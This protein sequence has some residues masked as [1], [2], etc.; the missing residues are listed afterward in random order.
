MKPEDIRKTLDDFIE[1][2]KPDYAIMLTGGWGTGKTYFIKDYIETRKRAPHRKKMIFLSLYG[3]EN[4]AEIEKQLWLQIAQSSFPKINNWRKENKA[5]LCLLLFFLFCIFLAAMRDC[6]IEKTISFTV[7]IIGATSLVGILLWIYDTLKTSILQKTLCNVG[8][9]IFD[10][11]ERAEMSRKQLLA[12]IN[13]YVEHLNKHVVIVCNKE[14]IKEDDSDHTNESRSSGEQDS[15]SSQY[16]KTEKNNP[17]SYSPFLKMKEKVIGKEI[18]LEQ[19]SKSILY[20]LWMGG[21]FSRLKKAVNKEKLGFDWFVSVTTPQTTPVNYRVWRRCCRDYETTF[22]GIDESVICHPVVS[23]QLI[24]FFFPVC[25][26]IQ[27]HD[28]GD[29]RLFPNTNIN[30]LYRLLFD[31]KR[32]LKWFLEMFPSYRSAYSNVLNNLWNEILYHSKVDTNE[33]KKCLE[34]IVKRE[35]SFLPTLR[36]YYQQD[37][38]T[39]DNAWQELK[40]AYRCHSVTDPNDIAD[41]VFSIVDM[42]SNQCCPD[43]SL[44]IKEVASLTY[45]YCEEIVFSI[46]DEKSFNSSN[47]SSVYSY[48][49]RECE[50]NSIIKEILDHLDSKV[51]AQIKN[52]LVPERFHHLLLSLQNL[53]AF[54]DCWYDQELRIQNIFSYQ[55]PKLL[56]DALLNSPV[57]S[58]RMIILPILDN[59]TDLPF[60]NKPFQPY[61]EFKKGLIDCFK[62]T[63]NNPDIHLQRTQS[64][65]FKA[66]IAQL[67]ANIKEIEERE[68]N[69]N[70]TSTSTDKEPEQ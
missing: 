9:I 7:R 4:E 15:Q 23:Q 31:Q 59:L 67:F 3:V 19:D 41:I 10:D 56:V 6:G 64:F 22:F 61:V 51:Q 46:K 37:D 57:Q 27:I 34:T 63:L 45:S 47:F 54:H 21:D 28:F 60:A 1:W 50:D 14:E 40:N 11:F 2:K 29:N 36:Y 17:P 39:M 68:K 26:G 53:D 70:K 35:S 49:I 42:I 43:S 44:T 18:V 52:V 62:N 12:Y 65:Y 58:L 16:N 8:L 25:Y 30:E 24:T 5:T 20:H 48:R 32:P 33:I 13:R 69:A 38:F 66:A 55:D